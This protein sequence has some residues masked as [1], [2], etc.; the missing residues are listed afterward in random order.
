MKREELTADGFAELGAVV[1]PVCSLC[2]VDRPA[3]CGDL[4]AFIHSVVPNDACNPQT[5]FCEDF[6]TAF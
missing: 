3:I 1:R 6:V 2:F 4:F 5:I